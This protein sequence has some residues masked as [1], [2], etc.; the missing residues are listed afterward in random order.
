M[1]TGRW[2]AHAYGHAI[3]VNAVENP[4]VLRGRVL[5]PSARRNVDRSR[6]R[7]G[8]AVDGGVVVAAFASVGW[9]WGGRWTGTPDYQHFSTTGR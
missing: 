8:M 1:T 3:D 5:P 2:S 7:P 6:Y 9:K 4:Y